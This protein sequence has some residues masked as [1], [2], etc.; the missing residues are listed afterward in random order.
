MVWVVV[1]YYHYT[2]RRIVGVGSSEKEAERLSDLALETGRFEFTATEEY[3][4]DSLKLTN[5]IY[6]TYEG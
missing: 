3:K 2:G 1:G 4:L 6:S 5:D